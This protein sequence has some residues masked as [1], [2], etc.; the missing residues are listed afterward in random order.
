M[1]F[2]FFGGAHTMQ[3][4]ACASMYSCGIT[5]VLNINTVQ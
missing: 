5:W 2:F 1:K 4:G 3:D